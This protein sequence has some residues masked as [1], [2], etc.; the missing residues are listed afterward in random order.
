MDLEKPPFQ[1]KA[2]MSFQ[3]FPTWHHT[4]IA[5]P[6]FGMMPSREGV[7]EERAQYQGNSTI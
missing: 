4:L 5:S 2:P 3:K 1:V 7:G 6:V